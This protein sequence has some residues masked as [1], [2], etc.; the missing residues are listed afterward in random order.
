MVN[1]AGFEPA[2]TG[3][4]VRN[5]PFVSAS[6]KELTTSDSDACTI[7]CTGQ[8]ILDL[9]KALNALSDDERKTLVAILLG[10]S[11]SAQVYTA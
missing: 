3:L 4:K 6:D 2:A 11:L 5:A 7:A 1:G 8:H 9:V 10:K